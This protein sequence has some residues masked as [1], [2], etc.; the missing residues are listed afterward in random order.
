MNE[1]EEE[2]R[3]KEKKE[4]KGLVRLSYQ[5]PANNTFILEQTWHQQPANNTFLSKQI[6]TN[7]KPNKQVER[8]K[9]RNDP[10]Y[11]NS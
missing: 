2:E 11:L 1:E 8:K 4:D 3:R 5:P 9:K 7:H 10:P 6:S